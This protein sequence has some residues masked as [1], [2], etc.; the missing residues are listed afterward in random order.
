[1]VG[2]KDIVFGLAIVVPYGY[3]QTIF[4]SYYN[5]GDHPKIY[6]F[7]ALIELIITMGILIKSCHYAD[8]SHVMI[9]FGF[10]VFNHII[11]LLDAVTLN[12]TLT[13]EFQ[14]IF[15]ILLVL[16][17]IFNQKLLNGVTTLFNKF[18]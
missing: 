4:H 17:I 1:M 9:G 13:K 11:Y 15:C 14:M 12:F 18:M 6:L 3:F 8:M 7:L 16:G 5:I 10:I 2:F